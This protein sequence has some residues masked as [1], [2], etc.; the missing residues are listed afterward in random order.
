GIRDDLKRC[1]PDTYKQILSIAYYLILEDRNPLSRFACWERTHEH[2]YA[3][4]IASQRSAANSLD[5]SLRMPRL[6]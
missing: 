6:M 3:K 4:E 5:L 2:P 1:F